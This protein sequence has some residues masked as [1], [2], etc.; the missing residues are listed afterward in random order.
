[1]VKA[2]NKTFLIASIATFLISFYPNI[3]DNYKMILVVIAL[4][5]LITTYFL[6]YTGSIDKIEEEINKTEGKIELNEKL[7]NTIK[8]IVILNKIK[9]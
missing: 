2:F 9:K 3:E 5:L 8:D 1:L 6:S 7:L 4:A